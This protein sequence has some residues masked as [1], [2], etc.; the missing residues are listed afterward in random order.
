MLKKIGGM[1]PSQLNFALLHFVRMNIMNRLLLC[2]LCLFLQTLTANAQLQSPSEFLGYRLGQEFT[3]YHRVNDYIHHVAATSENVIHVEYGRSYE[4]RS[5]QYL[6]VSSVDNLS[7]LEEIRMSNLQR[8]GLLDGSPSEHAPVIVWLSYNVHGNESVGTETALKVLHT[9]A[10]AETPKIANWLDSTIVILDPCLNPDG[11]ERYVHFYRQTRGSHAN[12]L[13]EAREHSEPW[14]GGRTNHYYFDLNRDWAWG[15]QAETRQRLVHYNRWMPHIHVDFHEQ[16]VNSPYFFPPAAAP[17]HAYIT[18]WQRELQGLIGTNHAKYF[19]AQGWLFFTQQVFD[20]F[21]PGYGDTWPTFN[22]AIGMTYEQAGSGQAGLGIITEE[23]DT[24]TLSDR[25]EHHYTT[26]LSTIEVAVKARQRIIGEFMQYFI[27][28]AARPTGQHAM[29]VVR[30]RG[31]EDQ[32]RTLSEHLDMQGIMY[33][34][35]LDQSSES[36]FSYQS[37]QQQR[38]NIESGDLIIPAAQPKGVLAAVLFEPQPVLEDTL[39]YDITAWALPYVYGVEAYA[40]D[41][42]IHWGTDKP[43]KETPDHPSNPVAYIAE[44]KSFE[45]A[46]F[47]AQLLQSDIRVRYAEVPFKIHDQTYTEG[48]LIMTRAQQGESFDSL[49][50]QTA[51]D[52]HQLVDGVTTTLVTEGVD[53]GSSDVTYIQPPR[54]AILAGPSISSNALGQLWHFFDEQ[55]EYPV[56]LI[57]TDDIAHLRLSRYDVI[58]LPSGQYRD[59]LTKKVMEDLRDWITKGGRLIALERAVSFLAKDEGF[60]INLKSDDEESTDSLEAHMIPYSERNRHALS[61]EIPGAFF[62]VQLDTT[63]PLAFGYSSYY[64]T[65]KV[66]SQ[67]F[68][69]LKDGWNI[70]M[71]KEGRPI[72]GFA[73]AKTLPPLMESLII[74]MESIG[75]GEVI[76]FMD[77]P[78]YRGFHYQG[79]LLL[80]NAIFLA[81]Q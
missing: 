5:L 30:H 81:G 37:G 69:P 21:Y 76:Y 47:L 32:V 35:A 53:F 46:K 7:R 3:P 22:G 27:D 20:L 12:V 75:R 25:I 48:S 38:V 6:I 71:L 45:D 59:V 33:G 66:G 57:H 79:R 15:T 13:E 52:S 42:D 60:S 28:S 24:L 9:L 55:L 72:A 62:Q 4:D 58:L 2:L 36:G 63:H 49:I 77:N 14:P 1:E 31:Q 17:F 70:G 80:A 65:L 56:T 64:F 73:G 23:G 67:A 8:A 61:K 29:Y 34:Y 40:L 68:G 19:D 44:W 10:S 43:V 26:T 74:G 11:R 51:L 39:T 54:I 41:Q 78:I 50:I 18:P 16:S